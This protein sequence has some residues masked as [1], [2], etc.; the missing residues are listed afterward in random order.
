MSKLPLRLARHIANTIFVDNCNKEDIIQDCLV[1]WL[2]AGMPTNTS[3]TYTIMKRRIINSAKRECRRS[4]LTATLP[5]TPSRPQQLDHLL[6]R[7]RKSHL[8]KL[9]STLSDSE[10][11]LVDALVECGGDQQAASAKCGLR[12]DT[13]RVRL[14]RLRSKLKRHL[15]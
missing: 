15:T 8:L 3:L 14:F 9:L 4:Q 5:A 11:Q 10:K 13:F 2:E 12:Y 7:E 6:A 1:A